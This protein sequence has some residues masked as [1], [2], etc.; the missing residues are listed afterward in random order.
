M[1]AELAYQMRR[2]STLDRIRV[3]DSGVKEPSK[4]ADPIVFH[5][6]VRRMPLNAKARFML[7]L[8]KGLAT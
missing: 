6:D 3:K 4:A 7:Q 8:I 1:A 5:A 2:S